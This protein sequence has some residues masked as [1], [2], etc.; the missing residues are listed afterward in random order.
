VSSHDTRVVIVWECSCGYCIYLHCFAVS[1]ALHCSQLSS[2]ETACIIGIIGANND[3]EDVMR[4]KIDHVVGDYK[5]T[6]YSS[7]G[8]AQ[9]LSACDGRMSIFVTGKY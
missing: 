3:K 6:R 1:L 8:K 5:L 9:V 4:L 7:C 2:E